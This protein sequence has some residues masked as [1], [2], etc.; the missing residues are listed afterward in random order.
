M[1][2]FWKIRDH[3]IYTMENLFKKDWKGSKCMCKEHKI[4]YRLDA[5][6]TSNNRLHV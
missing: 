6:Y 3:I 1:Y 5:L 2:D 4:S